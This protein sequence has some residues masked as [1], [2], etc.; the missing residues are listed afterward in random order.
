MDGQKI[1][2]FPLG[3]DFSSE[4]TKPTR[5]V[6][7]KRNHFLMVGTLEPRKGHADVLHAFENLWSENYDVVLSI[8]GKAGW[9]T[10]DLQKRL[11]THSEL[12]RRLFWHRNVL[13]SQLDKIYAENDALIS[14]SFGEGYGL[15]ILEGNF[16]GLI[17]VARDIPVFREV[18]P[19]GT[20]FFNSETSSLVD[21]I[22][23]L[24][25]GQ[26]KIQEL[27]FEES[28]PLPTWRD[29]A[30]T[31]RNQYLNTEAEEDNESS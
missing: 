9:M 4:K 31:L 15:P 23:L 5:K 1:S 10:H 12:G 11:D 24:A 17:N 22:K 25:N 21:Q 19:A 18:A 3:M 2:V 27:E 8:V 29:S 26:H 16:Y 28:A 13:D 6:D 30:R 14:A 20:L 7:A